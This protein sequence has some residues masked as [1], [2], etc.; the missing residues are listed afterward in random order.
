MEYFALGF[1]AGV[2]VSVLVVAAVGFFRAPIEAV[3]RAAG[4]ALANAGPRPRG[5]VIMPDDEA[6]VA[7]REHIEKNRREGKDTPIAELR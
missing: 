2:A 1:L 6:E 5:M 7:R 4:A 3:A